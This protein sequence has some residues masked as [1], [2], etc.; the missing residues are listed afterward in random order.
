MFGT[1]VVATVSAL[2]ELC[3]RFWDRQSLQAT[4]ASAMTALSSLDQPL[5]V[6]FYGL[7]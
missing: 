1:S 2:S 3:F 5:V 6:K 4:V 7:T